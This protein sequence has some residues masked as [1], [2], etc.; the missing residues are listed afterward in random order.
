MS[1]DRI[2]KL[3]DDYA[4]GKLTKGHFGALR[5]MLCASVH[6]ALS[7]EREQCAVT[8]EKVAATALPGERYDWTMK[9]YN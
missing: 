2:M 5:E 4:G 3:A 7:E 1:I 9:R 8:W 6:A